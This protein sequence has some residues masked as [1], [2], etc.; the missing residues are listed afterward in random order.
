M[1]KI[2]I[3][4]T[5]FMKAEGIS[6]EDR[7]TLQV[8]NK[9]IL[10]GYKIIPFMSEAKRN[11]Y[12]RKQLFAK[13]FM[14]KQLEIKSIYKTDE[15]FKFE[16]LSDNDIYFEF[17]NLYE[18]SFVQEEYYH[19]IHKS[20]CEMHSYILLADEVLM[21]CEQYNQWLQF[22]FKYDCKINASNHKIKNILEQFDF[23]ADIGIRGLKE[24]RDENYE[25]KLLSIDFGM[26][27]ILSQG[28]YVVSLF[29]EDKGE[30]NITRYHKLRMRYPK[31]KLIICF[32]QTGSVIENYLI[33]K[34][35]LGNDLVIVYNM[36]YYTILN[37]YKNAQSVILP[38]G[39]IY[40]LEEANIENMKGNVEYL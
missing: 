36:D 11:I 19:T 31:T 3:N 12:V 34:S 2:F 21:Q 6:C 13:Y 29:D 18:E 4:I 10:Q 33:K 8:I 30:I 1:Q 37:L 7:I 28:T 38:Y 14:T 23:K 35:E 25:D 16:V 5:K 20:G 26:K 24:V 17:D 9:F 40:K 27:Q 15:E 22:H 39:E 32:S